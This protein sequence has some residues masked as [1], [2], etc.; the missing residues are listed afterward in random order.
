[1]IASIQGVLESRGGPDIPG[2]VVNVG[3][4]SLQVHVP[5]ST[6]ESLG[7]VG[8]RVRLYTYLYFKEDNLALYGFTTME[9]RG[10]FQMLIGV[11][12]VGPKAALSMLSAMRPESLAQ[13]I[14]AE[15]IERLTQLPGVGRKLAGRLVLEL[16]GKLE[17]RWGAVIPPLQE[18]S[19]VLS[20]L[21]SLGYSPSEARAALSEIATSPNLSLEERIRLALQHLGSRA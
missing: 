20:A 14:A 4:V 15:D 16:K 1:M 13:A 3:G 10:L 7:N 5:A 12:R 21:L 17:K 11:E 2:V 19:E 18:D 6:L 8:E 9:E